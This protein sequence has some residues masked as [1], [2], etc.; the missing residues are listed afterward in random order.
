MHALLQPVQIGFDL[1]ESKLYEVLISLQLDILW[2]SL[3]DAC[4][5]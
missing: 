4:G 3:T 2:I 1:P 5:I